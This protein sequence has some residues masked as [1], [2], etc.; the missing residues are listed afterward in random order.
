MI[1]FNDFSSTVMAYGYRVA[2]C[3]HH[4]WQI[5]GGEK[6]SIVNVWANTKRGFRYQALGG[7]AKTGSLLD[8]MQLAGSPTLHTTATIMDELTSLPPWKQPERVGLIRKLW[9]MI[10]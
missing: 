5:L 7:K 6:N 2:Q 4:H 9:R 3:N 10:W 1:T 8:A